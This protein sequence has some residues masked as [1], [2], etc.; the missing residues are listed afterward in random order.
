L[1]ETALQ[2]D[3]VVP[4]R[5]EERG[6]S[7]S[8]R[9]LDAYLHDQFPFTARIT[10][11]DNG[12]T[13]RTW[14]EALAL[15]ADLDLVRAVRLDRPGRGGALRSIWSQREATVLCY[16][17]VDLSTDL[18]ALLPLLA[19]LL[20]GHSD[21]AI[22]TRLAT[23]A[24]V[25]LVGLSRNG[26]GNEF[27]GAAA[28]AG[29]KSWKAFLFGS[30]DPASFI[31][32][33]KPPAFLWVM[34]LS[35]RIFGPNYWSLLVPQALE[36]VA[37]VAVLYT[38]VRRWFG[39]GAAIMAGAVLAVTPVA[40]LIFRF[41]DPDALLTLMMTVAAY[42]ATR[43]I[44]SGHTRWLV[45]TGALLGVGFLAK[46]LAAFLV[47]P[48]LALA[49][50]YAGPPRIGKR[51]G[52][53]L[54]GGAALLATAGW[55]VAIDLLTPAADRPF[56]GST[57][58]NNILQL[59]FGY[60]GLSRLTGNGGGPGG[61]AGRAG[62]GGAG[63]AA[64]GG[65]GRAAGGGTAGGAGGTAGGGTAAGAGGQRG[66]GLGGRGGGAGG[67]GNATLSSAFVRL[68]TAGAT[69]YTWAAATDGSDSAAAMELASG[70]VP[71]M[72]IGGFRGTDPAPTLAEFERL[73]SQHKIHYFIAGGRGGFA[74][75]R[76]G[77]GGGR[78]GFGGAG[79]PGGGAGR[80]DAAE[81]TTWVVAHFRAT[82][83][84]G[85]TVYALSRVG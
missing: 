57:T 33:D 43:A 48:A 39:P 67:A 38:T 13:D 17:D 47:L 34:E 28:Q 81:I 71:V 32:V 16:M 85:E 52:Q 73:V 8:I 42:A 82:T 63:G 15:E 3:L 70:G 44:E 53:L 78:G 45:F 68:L 41:D 5:D 30:L 50:L 51:I 22:G 23:G 72:A 36:G 2:V 84:G 10:I 79:G 12:S 76:G 31:A 35:G 40:T 56:V 66:G 58:D 14:P 11:A 59:T 18:N 7:R 37:A 64:G 29:T 54:A 1:S 27:Y 49:Y 9:R 77:F 4:V 65:A 55:W 61:G 6:L 83:A 25:I 62:G 80:S 75:G 19:P 60:N 26:W 20:S 21:V 24:R 46:M 74:G 69:G